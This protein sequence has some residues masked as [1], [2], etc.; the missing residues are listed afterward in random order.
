VT[1]TNIASTSLNI[2]GISITAVGEV[3][4]TSPGANLRR[5]PAAVDFAETNDCGTSVAPGA[6]CGI[7]VTFT[8]RAIGLAR[9]WLAISDD[10]GG[11]PQL[12]SLSGD[13]F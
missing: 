7:S 6:S 3:G 12:V 8:P 9:G 5:G 1:L 11:S 10:G 2:S 13:G 4:G